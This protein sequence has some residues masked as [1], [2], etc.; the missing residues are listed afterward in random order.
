MKQQRITNQYY[1]FLNGIYFDV[2]QVKALTKIAKTMFGS[3]TITIENIFAF[4]YFC[5]S[6]I[7]ESKTF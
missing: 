3:C 2:K 1:L 4:K 6:N 5:F 7:R